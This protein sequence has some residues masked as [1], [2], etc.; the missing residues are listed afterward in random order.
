MTEVSSIAGDGAPEFHEIL[1]EG[2]AQTRFRRENFD[3]LEPNPMQWRV[4]GLLTRVGVCFVAGP[5]GSGKSFWVLDAMTK[6]C[7]G[8]PILGRTT[9]PGAVV[10]VASEGGEGFRSRI[11]GLRQKIGPLGGKFSFIGQAPDLTSPDDVAELRAVLTDAKAEHAASG[12]HLSV[13]VIDTL[14]ASTPGADENTARDMGPVLQALQLLA[15][16][17]QILVIM[18]AHT[19]K[20][21]GRGMRGWSGIRGNADGVIMIE[22]PDAKGVRQGT[23]AKVKDG[24]D[25]IHF[26]FDLE[27]VKIGIDDDGEDITTC[28]IREKDAT[29]AFTG[30]TLKD[31]EAVQA[32]VKEADKAGNPYRADIQSDDWVGWAIADVL[33]MLIANKKSQQSPNEKADKNRLRSIVGVWLSTGV[34][35][36]EKRK[37][38]SRRSRDFVVSGP[39]L[40]PPET[41]ER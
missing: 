33:G 36:I 25:N 10:Y 39:P 8:L 6:V 37:D 11:K 21:E 26:S 3:V 7:R 34:L 20:D 35:K 40:P 4:K 23:V 22:S 1:S 18:V 19:G 17:L 2:A 27:V 16:D 24:Q 15:Q 29:G 41:F 12:E 30:V 5:S 13:V 31:V 14:S 28:V 32:K 9:M 38:Q